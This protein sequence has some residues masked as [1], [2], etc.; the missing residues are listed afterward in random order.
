ME[1]VYKN[2]QQSISSDKR[3]SLTQVRVT[4]TVAGVWV[5]LTYQPCVLPHFTATSHERSKK[6]IKMGEHKGSKS[7]TLQ[8]INLNIPLYFYTNKPTTLG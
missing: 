7:Q 3:Q 4:C 5:K 6:D 8:L 2:W 1:F